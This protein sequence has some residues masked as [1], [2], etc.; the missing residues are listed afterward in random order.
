MEVFSLELKGW[1]TEMTKKDIFLTHPSPLLVS[2]HADSF[3]GF[4]ITTSETSFPST[5]YSLCQW[6][7]FVLL[8][9]LKDYN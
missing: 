5:Q 8:K 7:S 3:G 2:S 9:A 4:E 6:K 1:C